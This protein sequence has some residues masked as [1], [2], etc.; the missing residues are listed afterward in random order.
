MSHQLLVRNFTKLSAAELRL[1]LARRNHPQVRRW[2]S[3]TA[4]IGLE[5]HL[6][7]CADLK[8]RSD[9]LMLLAS[10]DG[11]PACVLSFQAA[12]S[13]WREL[14]D[15]GYYAFDPATCP[16]S[17]IAR[18]VQLQLVLLRGIKHSR[19]KIRNDNELALAINECHLGYHEVG[20][21][22]EFT[23]FE[24]DFCEPLPCYQAELETKLARL[25]LS[26][27]LEF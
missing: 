14:V 20:H 3:N 7:F 16:A 22:A 2:M 11:M 23:Y 12:D 24:Q 8:A 17:T 1:I 21:D 10:Y 4:P 26:L 25:H 15:S 18:L 19:V 9:C 13:T 6:R 5:E 27:E